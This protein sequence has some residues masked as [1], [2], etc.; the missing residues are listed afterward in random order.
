MVSSRTGLTPHLRFRKAV[1]T[2]DR[3]NGITHCPIE[4][5]GV[6]LDYDVSRQPNSAE[7][8]HIIPKAN[9]GTDNPNNGRAICRQCNQRRGNRGDPRP[10]APKAPLQPSAGW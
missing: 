10:K 6:L 9:G 1:L 4:G 5:C 2:R 8:D 7:P 3:R